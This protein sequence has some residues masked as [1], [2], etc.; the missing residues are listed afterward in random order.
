MDSKAIMMKVLMKELSDEE[1]TVKVLADM[2]VEGDGE[3]FFEN[4]KVL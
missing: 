4:I 2:P 1:I 3:K